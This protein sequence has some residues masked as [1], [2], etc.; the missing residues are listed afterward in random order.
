MAYAS[1]T[2]WKARADIRLLG[3]LL[4]DA[5]TRGNEA[6]IDADANGILAAALAGA[7]GE[8]DAALQAASRY[9]PADISG[10]GDNSLALLK[11][12]TVDLAM[13]RL[14]RRRQGK[15]SQQS[16]RTES[17]ERATQIL[18]DLAR[19]KYQFVVDAVQDASQPVAD[20]PSLTTYENYMPI[21]SATAAHTAPSRARFRVN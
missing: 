21:S 5:N 11:D 15:D 9:L 10:L 6:A 16:M 2:D 13:A 12:I 20:S 17:L 19:G 18:S 1:I 14:W 4:G 8:I 7:S 3:D